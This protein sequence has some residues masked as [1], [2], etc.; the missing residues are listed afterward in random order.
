MAD[1]VM[2]DAFDGM[3]ETLEQRVRRR[4]SNTAEAEHI[5][6]KLRENSI[7]M[8]EVRHGITVAGYSDLNCFQ[9]AN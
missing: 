3:S 9:V 2:S 7:T 6:S 8:A 5:L 4:I 1:L